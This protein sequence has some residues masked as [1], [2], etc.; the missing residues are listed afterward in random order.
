MAEAEVEAQAE[1]VKITSLAKDVLPDRGIA[2]EDPP[3]TV[4]AVSSQIEEMSRQQRL[5]F[6][7][8][9]SYQAKRREVHLPF[10]PTITP[11]V[12]DMVQAP[13]HQPSLQS[14]QRYRSV[15]L[16]QDTDRT[17]CSKDTNR[18]CGTVTG[19]W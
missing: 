11:R 3:S 8:L 14:K 19:R 1:E 13:D 4:E 17:Q 5:T 9:T 12:Q 7:N 16:R 15:S 18:H 10:L 6:P 2:V